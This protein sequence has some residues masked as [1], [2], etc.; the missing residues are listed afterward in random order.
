MLHHLLEDWRTTSGSRAD[1]ACRP[2][3]PTPES[4]LPSPPE[5]AIWDIET[6]A[7]LFL[8]MRLQDKVAKTGTSRGALSV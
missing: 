2:S 7:G 5:M 4:T 1:K 8:G 6:C 3:W